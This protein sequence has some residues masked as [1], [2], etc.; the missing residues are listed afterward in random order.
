MSSG[1]TKEHAEKIAAK[2]DASVEPGANH[3]LAKIYHKGKLVAQ[4]GIRRSSKK[5]VPHRYVP[6]QIFATKKECLNL[7]ECRLYRDGWIEILKQ[8]GL[9]A[10][11]EKGP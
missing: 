11:D 3:D 2:L 7:A 10:E 6:G 5:D 4:F 8:K 9:I 1:I